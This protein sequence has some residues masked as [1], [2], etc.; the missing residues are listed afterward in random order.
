MQS[1]WAP[2]HSKA[3]CEYFARGM[4]FSAIIYAINVKFKTSYTRSA[5][6]GRATRMALAGARQSRGGTAS[7]SITETTRLHR[8]HERANSKPWRPP[9]VFKATE[10]APLR[11]ADVVPRR[12]SLLEL[13]CDDCR[14]PYG[15]DEEGEAITFCGHPRHPGSS[16]CAAH[17]DLSVG[18]GTASERAADRILLTIVERHERSTESTLPQCFFGYPSF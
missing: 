1:N 5:V 10:T 13:E 15:G 17:F 16:Y 3:L 2:A 6:L 8:I 11:C 7:A 9:P 12:L 18:P 14:Y 4:S